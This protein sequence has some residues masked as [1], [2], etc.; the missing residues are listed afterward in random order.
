[1]S[2]AWHNDELRS[3]FVGGLAPLPAHV[4]GRRHTQRVRVGRRRVAPGGCLPG[5]SIKDSFGSL[6]H[7]RDSFRL[8]FDAEWIHREPSQHRAGDGL[9]WSVVRTPDELVA[10][11]AAHGG[12]EVFGPVLL[13]DPAVTILMARD[14]QGVSAGAI[15]YRSRS[16]IGVS[17]L[18][19]TTAD[20]DQAWAGAIAVI[21][22]QNP[23]LPLVGYENGASLRAARRAGFVSVGPLRVWMK[24]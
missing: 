16:V 6:D 20:I 14:G 9:T 10:W 23:D 12:G 1:M 4:P 5:C 2:S 3:E 21:S 7:A 18:F 13:D 19:T 8:L 24:D 17:N 15:G 11:G 22:A